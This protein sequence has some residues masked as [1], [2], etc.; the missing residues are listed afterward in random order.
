[1]SFRTTEC[2]LCRESDF[3]L[4]FNTVFSPSIAVVAVASTRRIPTN[5]VHQSDRLPRDSD[6]RPHPIFVHTKSAAH[7]SHGISFEVEV[8]LGQVKDTSDFHRNRNNLHSCC[9]LELIRH[10]TREKGLAMRETT[11]NQWTG[12]WHTECRALATCAEGFRGRLKTP[13][14]QA[15][16]F[17]ARMVEGKGADGASSHGSSLHSSKRKNTVNCRCI[18]TPGVSARHQP[19]RCVIRARGTL[20][21]RLPKE[22]KRRQTSGAMQIWPCLLS[23]KRTGR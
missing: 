21:T 10:G 19:Q 9:T 16:R 11:R 4:S 20:D 2:G 17:L 23:H 6:G 3:L 18:V 13:T 7:S 22:D 8:P 12:R 5:T 15:V 1:M 14:L